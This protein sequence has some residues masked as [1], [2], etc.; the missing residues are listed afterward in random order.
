VI[1]ATADTV[2]EAGDVVAVAGALP[3]MRTG[4]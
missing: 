3:Q 1:D 4:L 2:L